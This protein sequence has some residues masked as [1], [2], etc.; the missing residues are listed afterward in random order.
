MNISPARLRW[1][2]LRG[3]PFVVGVAFLFL[4]TVALTGAFFAWRYEKRFQAEGVP[5]VATVT[6]EETKLE[7]TQ[8]NRKETHFYLLYSFQ[9]AA[10]TTYQG[11]AGVSQDAW[12]HAKKGDTLAIQ[13]VRSEPSNNRPAKDAASAA[14]APIVLAGFGGLFAVIG[15]A[16]LGYALARAT[17]RVRIVRD[18]V[19]ALGVVDEL[20]IDESAGKV[21]GVPFYR[22]TYTFTDE[23]GK[24]N[25]GHSAALPRALQDR[26]QPGDPILILYDRANPTRN[27]ADIFQARADDLA[28]LQGA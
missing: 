20:E 4:G 11:R 17:R 23:D 10:G 9:D 7:T 18:G 14:W 24:T 2:Y 16:L 1:R 28:R 26:W 3:V 27:E 5:A 13:Y 6:G 15:L 22:L 25:E 21:N 8:K 12:Q 19:P